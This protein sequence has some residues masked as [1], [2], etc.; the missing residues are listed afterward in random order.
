[1]TNLEAI[2][3][4]LQPYPVRQSLVVRQCEKHDLAASSDVHDEI[5]ITLCVI[6]ILTQ[7]VIVNNVSEGGVGI[8]FNKDT[9]TNVIKR[10]CEEIGVD[11]RLY[12]QGPTVTRLE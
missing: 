10:K 9:V 7:M 3:E 2:V 6:E 11:S 4:D 5:K 12:I 1:M 8:S